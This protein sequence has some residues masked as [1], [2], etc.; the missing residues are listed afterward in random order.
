[1]LLEMPCHRSCRIDAGQVGRTEN[2]FGSMN[3][4]LE[5]LYPTFSFTAGRNDG[6]RLGDINKKRKIISI[7][8]DSN[9]NPLLFS[10]SLNWS[11]PPIRIEFFVFTWMSSIWTDIYPDMFARG[12]RL[13][14]EWM[15]V[16]L[17][18]WLLF[19]A[20]TSVVNVLRC[21]SPHLLCYWTKCLSCPR[22]YN[23]SQCVR[24]KYRIVPFILRICLGVGKYMCF[25]TS[26]Y[27]TI[28]LFTYCFLP[29]KDLL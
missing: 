22:T 1:M 7:W 29:K 12:R 21:N 13:L 15:I 9:Q 3:F 26:T 4:P 2:E 6:K 28:K 23:P 5:A 14:N 17:Y 25:N 10:V 20:Q 19:V 27:D 16:C 11:L 24:A 8:W 18:E